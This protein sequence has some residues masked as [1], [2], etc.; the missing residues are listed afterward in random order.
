[1][2]RARLFKEPSEDEVATEDRHASETNPVPPPA[3]GDLPA[4]PAPGLSSKGA[5]RRRFAKVGAGA[6]GVVL[7][8]YSQPGMACTYC[9]ISPSAAMSAVGQHKAIGTLSHKGPAAV[10][11]GQPPSYWC[12]QYTN[13][14]SGCSKDDAFHRHFSCTSYSNWYSQTCHGIT[15]GATC[16]TSRVAQ[17]IMAAYLN[18]LSGKVNFISIEALKAAWTEWSTKGYYEPMAGQKWYASDIVGYLAGTMD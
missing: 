15:T 6:T 14:P 17:Y 5:S 1:M 11:N 4:A 10:C 2:D 8:L 16:D 3:G 12:G 7:T 18:V 9:G 13:W